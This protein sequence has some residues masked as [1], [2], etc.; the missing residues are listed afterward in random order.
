MK[1]AYKIVSVIILTIFVFG[2]LTGFKY[3]STVKLVLISGNSVIFE[4]QFSEDLSHRN[5][6]QK[7]F[8]TKRSKLISYYK[9][10]NYSNRDIVLIFFPDMVSEI[11]NLANKLYVPASEATVKFLP[12]NKNMF[13]FTEE[14]TGKKLIVE[15]IYDEIIKQIDKKTINIDTVFEIIQ[16]KTTKD[17]LK[18]NTVLRA[19]FKTYY[20]SSSLTRKN[21]INQA[22][23][24]INGRV[25]ASG[26]NF[27]FNECVGP[28]SIARGFK[29]A[30][31]ISDGK[32]VKGVGGGVC[33]VS[34][35]LYNAVLYADLQ[36]VSVSKHSLPVSYVP[37]SFDAM[38]SSVTDFKFKN[39]TANNIYIRAVSD[40]VYLYINIYGETMDYE[41]QLISNKLCD[42]P[43]EVQ[44]LD[45]INT[46]KGVEQVVSKG[47]N[48]IESK[49][50]VRYVK[51]GNVISEHLIRHDLYASQKKIISRGV[52]EITPIKNNSDNEI[53]EKTA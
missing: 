4:K 48:G 7:V 15:K 3:N 29:E 13:E 45:D 12:K 39:N 16:P 28:R 6:F 17:Q 22:L 18:T 43:Y 36:V 35:T 10:K 51:N 47:I 5:F 19:S 20:G 14:K 8:Y 42:I 44:Y 11:E 40:N 50:Y 53:I 23:S 27:S 21:N 24:F 41:V 25:L 33:Q 9:D 52:K 37:A 32:F 49:G 2:N 30:L 31:I 46:E 38:V 1:R 26:E 34:T